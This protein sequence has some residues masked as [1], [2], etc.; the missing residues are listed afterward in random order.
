MG[1]T[2]TLVDELVAPPFA[3]LVPVLD[4][5]GPYREGSHT[6]P[7]FRS[8]ESFTLPSGDHD[9]GG[10]YGVTVQL[11]G[12]LPT[13]MGRKPGWVS[14]DGEYDT[15]RFYDRLVQVVLQHY[16]PLQGIYVTAGVWDVDMFP[17]TITWPVLIGSG[18]RVGLYVSPFLAFDLFYLCVL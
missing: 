10:T 1:L 13:S 15:T 7:S 9:V 8:G 4:L 3:T 2:T 18:A 14:P 6:L 16:L 17:L 5:N 12:A 11:N